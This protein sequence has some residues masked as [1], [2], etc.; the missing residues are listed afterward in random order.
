MQWANQHGLTFPVLQDT[1]W[2]VSNNYEHDNYIPTD[3]ILLPGLVAHKI[4]SGWIMIGDIENNLPDGYMAPPT[5]DTYPN[6]G[7]VE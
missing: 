5:R 1:N 3:S 4:D 2:T 7:I 6:N